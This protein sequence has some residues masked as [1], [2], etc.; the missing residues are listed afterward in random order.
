MVD[1]SKA[2]DT[3]NHNLLLEKLHSYGISGDELKWFSSYLSERKQRVVM[4]GVC[5][6]WSDVRTGVPQGSIL[7]PLLFIVFVNDLPS[8]VSHSEVCLY[9][10][11]TTVY[12]ADEDP[13]VV[14]DKLTE[15]LNAV[16]DWIDRNGLR[17][18]VSKTNL[19]VL[20]PK[21]DVPPV[22]LLLSKVKRSHS[23]TR[24]N[25]LGS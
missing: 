9:A 17:M 19:L 13:A 2:F 8:V 11:D 5:A 10:D 25:I 24:S 14:R 15:D 20:S 16:A 7:G 3:I 6:G 1:L 22:Y 18:N 21:G 4:N 12:V 23:R